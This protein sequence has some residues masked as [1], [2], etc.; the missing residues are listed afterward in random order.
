MADKEEVDALKK[1]RRML[2]TLDELLDQR[3][4]QGTYTPAHVKLEIEDKETEI[5]EIEA[6]LRGL[7]VKLE[8][9]PNHVEE[10]NVS[11]SGESYYFTFE[12]LKW[13]SAVAVI[14]V[15][16]SCPTSVQSC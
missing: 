13:I 12:Y 5:S 7:G 14:V 6:E 4:A 2:R 3:A 15:I 1:R 16:G 8:N 9:L 11:P 10:E